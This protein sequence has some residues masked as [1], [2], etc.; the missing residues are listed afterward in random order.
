MSI[1]TYAQFADGYYRL[2]CKETGRYLAVHNNYVNT[3][4]ATRT[5]QIY[6]QSLETITGFENIVNDPGSVIYLRN[7]SSGY[8]IDA[9]GFTTDGRDMYLEFVPVD[10]AYR[11][12][13][14]IKYEGQIVTRYLR[15]YE[16]EPGKSYI[17]TDA[18]QSTN[19]NWY[20]IPVTDA[21]NQFMGLKGDV[22]VG[23]SY[24]TTIYA[25]FP[26]QLGS[27]MKAY[28]VNTLTE[29]NC[30]LEDIGNIVPAN[31]PVVIACA[32]EGASS[33]KVTPL[34]SGIANV[35]DNYLSGVVFCYPSGRGPGSPAWNA[36][37]YLPETMRLL[38]EADGK[39]AFITASDVK[40]LPANRAYLNVSAGSASSIPTDGSTGIFR[41]TT[42]TEN[43]QQAKGTYT[44]N[45]VRLPDNITPQKGIYIQ[46][47]KKIVI[48]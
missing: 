27:G 28:A 12:K 48:K 3:E 46:D 44:L 6:I 25:T 39:L 24:Y 16:E 10:D 40:Y 32:G 29:S 2:Q 21:D 18:N 15:D 33:N 37:D 23:N 43:P 35:G 19:W 31:I 45:G 14:N 1:G 8:V 30:T 47:G 36:K 17:I 22:K 5:G 41:V 11:L 20:V 7:T 34:A 9:Q 38:G 42:K 26:I 13:V 4:S